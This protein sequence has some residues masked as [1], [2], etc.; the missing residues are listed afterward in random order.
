MKIAFLCSSLEHGR[1]GVGDY[2]RRLSGELIRQGHSSI[3]VALN[4][5]HIS[6]TV[7]ES[8]EIEATP[9][10]VL[11]LPSGVPWSK[12]AIEVGNR[13]D[14]FNPDWVS[15]QF[16]AFGFHRKGLCFGLGKRLAPLS[17]N[18]SW[19]IMFHEL[20]LGL[21]EKASVKH[22][23]WGALQRVIILDMIRRLRPQIIHTQAE[24]YRIVLQRE[25][26]EASILPLFSNIPNIAGDGWGSLLE[27]L[28]TEAAGKHQDRTRLYLAGILGRVAPEWNV[29]QTVTTL[30]PLVQRFQKRLVLVFCGRNHITSEAFDKLKH[31]CR[32]R[33]DVVIAGERTIPEISR[34]LQALDIG[35]ATTPR[36]I[37]Q[38]SGS[39]AAM[40]EHGLEVLVTRDDWRLRG[41][42]SPPEVKSVRL[43]SPKEFGLLKTLPARS[44]QQAG[45]SR[46]KQV[47]GQM[48]AAMNLRFSSN[49]RKLA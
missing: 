7:F 15:L 39:V 24:S 11:R 23:V 20:W 35:V 33:A 45:E 13:L 40:L 3:A 31:T 37:I 38:K 1:D 18:A 10:S 47:S 27:P 16:V 5:P 46:L 9:I 42:D 25:R 28:V 12:R 44:H 36:Q 14:V 26:I 21:G 6:E 17:T 8:Q 22:R 48:L 49:S 41:P 32:N 19:H 29:E 30:L 43:L 2:A 4:D 34:I